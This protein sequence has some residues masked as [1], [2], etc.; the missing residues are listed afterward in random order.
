[1]NANPVEQTFENAQVANS[2]TNADGTQQMETA[3][4]IAEAEPAIDYKHKFSESSKEALRLHEENKE[5]ERLLREAQE[6]LE[7]VRGGQGNTASEIVYPGFEELDPEAQQNLLKFT[8][9]VKQQVR[10]EIYKDPSIAFAR[11]SFNEKKWNDAFQTVAQKYPELNESKEEFKSKYF[12]PQNVPDNVADILAD[13]AKV[14]LFDKA[15]S[16]GAQE[17]KERSERIDIE[18][19]KG[20][21]QAQPS[22][23]TT[24]DWRRMAQENPAKFASLSKEFQA[25]LESGR[26]TE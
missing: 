7:R 23:R 18:R 19:V 16:L 9:T 5:K 25:D 11:Q 1:M 6:E 14:H 10:D 26:L 3:N 20:G 21:T 15:R 13:L 4:P 22:G 17:E 12:Q 24:D 8:N 2:Q